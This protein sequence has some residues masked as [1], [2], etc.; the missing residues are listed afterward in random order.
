MEKKKLVMGV[1]GAD[2]RDIETT[3]NSLKNQTFQGTIISD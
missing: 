1:I 2:G 3:M